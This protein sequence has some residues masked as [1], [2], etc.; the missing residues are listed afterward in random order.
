MVKK[1]RIYFVWAVE[2]LLENL[3]ESLRNQMGRFLSFYTYSVHGLRRELVQDN[4]RRAFPDWSE[5]EIEHQSEKCYQFYGKYLTNFLDIDTLIDRKEIV[6]KNRGGLESLQEQG[7]IVISG[8]LGN[9]EAG[10]TILSD[11]LGEFY[12]YG[13]RISNP[14][15][16]EILRKHRAERGAKTINGK[17]APK[18][19]IN[20][21]NEGGVVGV[22]SDQRTGSENYEAS[23]FGT[24][25]CVSPIL[26]FLA[27]NTD[28]PIIPFSIFEREDQFELR[29]G[30]PLRNGSDDSP[31]INQLLTDYFTW[32]ESEI[33]YCPHQYFWFHNRW[34]FCPENECDGSSEEVRG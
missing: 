25:V 6:V 19:L 13:D 18:K 24:N 33:R 34:K 32:L 20:R 8:H 7:G 29:I 2:N 10:I 28:C 9:W 16:E 27:K 15:A 3:P 31:E 30:D 12:I 26:P 11:W 14:Y 17:M 1:L 5:D 4:L 22:A 21:I 23:F